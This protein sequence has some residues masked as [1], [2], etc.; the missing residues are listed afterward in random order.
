MG[1]VNQAILAFNRG[2][3]SKLG[4][5]RID[6]ARVALSAENQTNWFPRLL[7]S[8]ML[9]PGTQYLGNTKNNNKATFIPFIFSKTQ[10]A[11]IEFTDGYIRFWNNNDELI[12]RPSVSTT[13]LNGNFDSNLNNWTDNDQVGA[14]SSW[15]AGGY[16]QL[17]GTGV[18]YAIRTQSITPSGADIGIEH[19]VRIV[20]KR[21]PVRFK[22]GSTSTNDDYVKQITL[23]TGTH[24]LAFTPTGTFYISFL[25][26]LERITLVDS[27]EIESAGVLA[28]PSPYSESDLS[29][30]RSDQSL[31]I[32]FIACLGKQQRQLQRS[33]NGNSWS[34]V[35]FEPE[36]G[37]VRV[38]NTSEISITASALYGNITI[39]SNNT[40]FNSQQV[41][42]VFKHISVGQNVLQAVS[43]ENVFTD[44]IIVQGVG[45]VRTF[46]INITG[47]WTATITLQ[48]SFDEGA[49]WSDVNNYTS[50]ITTTINDSLDNQIVRYRIG[51]KTGNYTSGTAN[52]S[53]SYALGSI[54]GY[55]RITAFSSA[56]S[57]NAEVLK[58]L[59]STN[60]TTEWS[61]SEWSDYRGWPSCVALA[62]GRLFFGSKGKIIGSISDAYYSYDDD[63]GGDSGLISRDLGTGAINNPNWLISLY[64]LFIGTDTSVKA[65]KTTTFEEPM[66]PTN[67]RVVDT[68]TQSCANYTAAKIDKKA[69]FIQGSGTRI[70]ELNYD[71]STIDYAVEELTKA[72]PEIGQ[73]SVV[74]IAIQRQPDTMIHCVR[75]DGK[76][77]IL[78]Y[79]ILENLKGWFLFET[80]G[81]VEDVIVFT[82]DIEDD[83]YYSIKRTINGNIVRY[84]EK[85]AMQYECQGD[86]L[87]KQ[88][89][90]FIIYDG[91]ATN[92][93]N[94]LDHLEGENVIVWADGKDLSPDVN[95]IQTTYEVIGG[96]ITLDQE[97]SKAIIG[98]PYSGFYKSSKLAYASGAPLGQK[99]KI[100]AIGVII[101]NTHSHGLEYSGDGV[102]YD[103]LPR[104]NSQTG[105][106]I[107][108]DTIL[109]ELDMPQVSFAQ[110]WETDSRLYLKASAPRPCTLL[111]CEI[112]I[113]T[114]DKQ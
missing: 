49:S 10:R 94:G 89:D 108:Y 73:P 92:I 25:S 109:T 19:A 9:R 39:I 82:G 91:L 42:A 47:T 110:A 101:N 84:F 81:E 64:R 7:G 66:T 61:E 69:I 37:P 30:I 44:Y 55:F 93:I 97:V 31:D 114:N 88:A 57:V 46:V 23:G 77:A 53:L 40:L 24:S 8:M 98:L 5:A 4:L 17:V 106:I 38:K 96:Q 105:A 52:L 54:T 68:S 87:N 28:L 74:K 59:G 70:L 2:I 99:K 107:P 58:D 41:G 83:V 51:I 75:S 85:F 21:G 104:R 1:K 13:I 6:V 36:D 50:N 80:N 32:I 79:D 78:I 26:L 48:R 45:S 22:I 29:L 56:T 95:G 76:V 33:G 65:V 102:N 12:S 63:I 34:I 103:G 60:P 3:I 11:K 71:Q 111:A 62:E 18:N 112:A 113:T 14:S 20:I 72:C 16:M 67:F 43:A 90:S 15:A 100:N 27:I 35:L 86:I